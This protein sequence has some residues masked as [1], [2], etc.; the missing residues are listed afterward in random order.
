MGAGRRRVDIALSPPANGPRGSGQAPPR[1]VAISQSRRHP[2][3][4]RQPVLVQRYR[5]GASHKG[6]RME[7]CKRPPKMPS[8]RGVSRAE[9]AAHAFECSVGSR[10]ASEQFEAHDGNAIR[11][12]C[13]RVSALASSFEKC[14]VLMSVSERYACYEALREVFSRFGNPA[15]LKICQSS[16]S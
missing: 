4:H 6:G 5:D 15:S 16:A 14:T 9:I 10:D 13:W 3:Q 7:C 11:T 2:K 1:H 8:E 12:H